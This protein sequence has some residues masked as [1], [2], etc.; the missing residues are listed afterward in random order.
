MMLFILQNTL[1]IFLLQENLLMIETF[2]VFI[3]GLI[4]LFF[5]GK[6]EEVFGLVFVKRNY[7]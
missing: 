2:G 6:A 4:H 5:L 7:S 3:L 1:S